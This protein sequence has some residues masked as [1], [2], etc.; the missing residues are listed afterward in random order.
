MTNREHAFVVMYLR[1]LVGLIVALFL[2]FGAE[3]KDWSDQLPGYRDQAAALV[4]KAQGRLENNPGV[5]ELI[6]NQQYGS[7]IL[8]DLKSMAA[9]LKITGVALGDKKSCEEDT[10]TRAYVRIALPENGQPFVYNTIYYC[11][12]KKE[13][14]SDAK[15]VHSTLHEVTH[16]IGY[17]RAMMEV[18]YP[19]EQECVASLFAGYVFLLNGLNPKFDNSIYDCPVI[20]RNLTELSLH[21]NPLPVDLLASTSV[22]HIL[23]LPL[24]Q[25]KKFFQNP[26]EPLFLGSL[27]S[28]K[29]RK[30][31]CLLK[32]RVNNPLSQV[33]TRFQVTQSV[34]LPTLTGSQL[35]IG[36]APE[37]EPN[38]SSN[39]IWLICQS[40]QALPDFDL[41]AFG[42]TKKQFHRLSGVQLHTEKPAKNP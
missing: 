30:Y 5:L 38:E 24:F 1:L 26:S 27:L 12:Q 6:Q 42:F 36:L 16:L 39:D 34:L 15:W 10:D 14:L 17:N 35:K 2:V 41:K 21:L 3:A 37:K 8:V 18:T 32:S 7:N 31:S 23:E 11:P 13:T 4:E 20:S 9:R 19:E 22:G 40:N 29:G 33:T 28:F 25:A